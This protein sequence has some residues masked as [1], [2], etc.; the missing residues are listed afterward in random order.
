MKKSKYA[1]TIMVFSIWHALY[2]D[3]HEA[4]GLFQQQFSR[5]IWEPGDPLSLTI[6][7]PHGDLQLPI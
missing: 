4:L 2:D 6:P 5:Y 3:P 1:V 7:T